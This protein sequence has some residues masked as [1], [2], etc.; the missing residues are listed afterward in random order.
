[1][2]ETS[3]RLIV[4]ITHHLGQDYLSIVDCWLY[5]GS[6][7]GQMVIGDTVV[8]ELKQVFAH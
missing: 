3:W 2:K 6:Y 1:M 7:A 4:D 5:G 8:K